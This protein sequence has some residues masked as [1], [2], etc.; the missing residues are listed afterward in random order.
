[1][2]NIEN[3][4]VQFCGY[5]YGNVP[6]QLNAHING[7]LVFQ[8]EIPTLDQP[9]PTPDIDMSS[10]PV[11]FTVS[12][13]TLF[14]TD[15]SGSY[16]M[17][18]SVANGSGVYF[19]DVLSNYMLNI[20]AT[21]NRPWPGNATAFLLGYTGIPTNSDNNGDRYSSVTIDSITQVPTYAPASLG[22]YTWFVPS[23]S[24]FGCNFNIGLGNVAAT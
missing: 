5:A 2:Q 8:G 3:R 16:P 10:A 17:T 14:S 22:Y 1:M 23:G 9:V 19:G 20:D 6:V 13:N 11:L 15:F 4:T 18:V 7:T 12:E 21:P 24:T